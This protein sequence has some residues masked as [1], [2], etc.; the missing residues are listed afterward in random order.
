M[1]RLLAA[2][3][4]II[5]VVAGLALAAPLELAGADFQAAE[6]WSLSQLGGSLGASSITAAADLP[7][8]APLAR[9]LKLQCDFTGEPG[10]VGASWRGASWPGQ[11][12]KVSFWIHTGG[13]PHTI[14]L[15]LRDSSGQCFQ[16]TL[17]DLAAVKGWQRLETSLADLSSWFH[18]GGPD[19]GQVHY[20]LSLGE[21][22]IDRNAPD[23]NAT[24]F[25][26]DLRIRAEADPSELVRLDVVQKLK[27]PLV[28]DLD[29]LLVFRLGLTNLS[30]AASLPLEVEWN[31][32]DAAGVAAQSGSDKLLLPA[33]A[34]KEIKATFKAP[35]YGVWYCKFLVKGEGWAKEGAAS[36]AV[37]SKPEET[38]LINDSPWGMGIYFSRYGFDEL[39]T[40]AK[41]AQ[42]AGI[43]WSRE[44]FSWSSIQRSRDVWDWSRF[45]PDVDAAYSHGIQLFGLLDY[46][47]EAIAP[48]Y[49]ETGA[50]AFAEY[51]RQVVSRYKDRIKYWEVWNE[52]NI[53]PFW[54]GPRNFYA[55]V[56]EL[57]YKAIKEADPEARVMAF[58]T[59][60]VDLEFIKTILDEGAIGDFDLVSVHPYRYPPTPEQTDLVGQL[61][62]AQARL[63]EEGCPDEPMWITEMGWPTN[64]GGN[65]STE[66]KQAQMIARAYLLSL[67]SG[68]VSKIFWYN[69]RNDGFDPEYNEHNFGILRRP[70][71]PK[72]AF[73][74]YK[75]MTERL[76]GAPRF[77]R[78]LETT[79]DGNYVLEFKTGDQ[80]TFVCWRDDEGEAS[81]A[82]KLGSNAFRAWDMF[83][84]LLPIRGVSGTANLTIGPSP[85]Y[86][87]SISRHIEASVRDDW[88]TVKV[89]PEIAAPGQEAQLQARLENPV[90]H[91]LRGALA[92]DAEW[93]ESPAAALPVELVERKVISRSSLLP[94]SLEPG[95]Y[96]AK[97][98]LWDQVNRGL[99]SSGQVSVQVPIS[100]ELRPSPGIASAFAI[101]LT[102][103]EPKLK[104]LLTARFADGTV[105][106]PYPLE[107]HSQESKLVTIPM[108]ADFAQT[109]QA[110]AELELTLLGRGTMTAPVRF[111]SLAVS[112]LATAE[113]DCSLAL[114]PA[115]FTSLTSQTAGS[116]ED[117]SAQAGFA[118]A[119]DGLHFRFVV[120]DDIHAEGPSAAELWRGDSVQLAL[121]RALPYAAKEDNY[122]EVGFALQGDRPLLY[123]WRTPRGMDAAKL[124]KASRLSIAR[125]GAST[126]YEGALAVADWLE[127][128]SG[129]QF[130]LSFLVNENDGGGREGWLEWGGG[131][132]YHKNPADFGYAAL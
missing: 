20:P 56:L 41:L 34:T 27:W 106:G 45:D 23:S 107:F 119:D 62:N 17:L 132:G 60:G 93:E 18:F 112:K 117:L 32:T 21:L 88:F 30:T 118:W 81:I 25:F 79:D 66:L 13:T 43:K 58:S 74:S 80:T 86:V 52:P 2:V 64:L 109:G 105:K 50:K 75:T 126:V 48:P 108:P 7:A 53:Q 111:A 76:G 129:A 113:P 99:H 72:P 101:L 121:S 29:E 127:L 96:Q 131:I 82:L 103:K 71:E 114:G 39:D 51:C 130:G 100:L 94:E 4:T 19:D 110:H 11:P 33:G 47:N 69:Y 102:P 85:I 8:G 28:F 120:K 91:T 54:K 115:N 3:F 123:I 15:R 38:G 67:A 128:R 125:E 116:A 31:L 9:G 6:G 83:G 59:A 14:V 77:I 92:F 12:E 90:R 44:E 57:A 98:T 63:L 78:R 10:Y 40:A 24:I 124:V 37:T 5:F 84:N 36:I 22:I 104:G 65:G 35:R 122:L 16:K 46:W 73:L 89:V 61:Q 1:N 42:Q 87:S 97:A 70:F 49:T 55:R 26:A 95:Q 68:A